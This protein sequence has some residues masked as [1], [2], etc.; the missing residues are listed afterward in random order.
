MRTQRFMLSH[1]YI[2]AMAEMVDT[3][4]SNPTIF[5]HRSPETAYNPAIRLTDWEKKSLRAHVNYFLR[6]NI[7]NGVFRLKVAPEGWYIEKVT[8]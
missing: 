4:H 2:E 6:R 1:A 5:W 3:S 7:L 8:A